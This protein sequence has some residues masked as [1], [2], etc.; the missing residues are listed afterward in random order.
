MAF[1][2]RSA[3]QVSR[4]WSRPWLPPH[5]H[6]LPILRTAFRGFSSGLDP[7]KT[8]GISRNA[9]EDDIKKAYR[10]KALKWHPD[11]H[12]EDK[13]EEAQKHF[14][15]AS[16]SYEI[17]KD[18]QTREEYDATGRV[19]GAEGRPSGPGGFHPGQMTQEQ[20]QHIFQQL[21]QEQ[22]LLQ[23]MQQQQFGCGGRAPR[24]RGV[25]ETDMEVRIRADVQNIHK[26]S[27]AANIDV[28]NDERRARY[29]GK[30]GTIVKTDPKDQSVKL[31]VMVSPGRADE[32]WFGAEGVWIPEDLEVD[33]EVQIS[34]DESIIHA[35]SREVGIDA[36]NDA[37]RGRCAGKIGTVIRIDEK[38]RSVKI[39]VIVLPGRADEVWFGHGAFEPLQEVAQDHHWARP[40]AADMR[41]FASAA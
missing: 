40:Q 6:R 23:R 38:D 14:S 19:G 15:D 24:Q 11:K 32:V 7:Y 36:E 28:E 31:R 33:R 10:E 16:N 17:L 1:F 13:R 3:I 26:A 21:M 37:R 29:A 27:R 5:L 34:P 9:S 30:M 12:P 35:A 4:H 8:L 25:L 41:G 39:R 2:S 20:M 18:P 22:E